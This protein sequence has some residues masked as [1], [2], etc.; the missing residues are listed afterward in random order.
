MTYFCQFCEWNTSTKNSGGVINN[1]D[2][3]VDHLIKSHVQNDRDNTLI[4]DRRTVS[5]VC[6]YINKLR[7]QQRY[8]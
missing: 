5:E 7:F 1:I 2:E 8:G 3:F 4:S 6:K